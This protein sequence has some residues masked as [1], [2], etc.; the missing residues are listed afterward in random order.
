MTM[1]FFSVLA[2]SCSIPVLADTNKFL[3]TPPHEFVEHVS[4]DN[5]NTSLL[6]EIQSSLPDPLGTGKASDHFTDIEASLGP[7]YAALPKNQYGNLEHVTARYALRRLFVLRHGWAIKGLEPMG[8]TYNSSS[9]AGVLKDQVPAYIEDL[10]EQRLQGRGFQLHELAVLAATIEHL[11]K[12]E[13]MARLGGAFKVLGGKSKINDPRL[14]LSSG[15]A[16]VMLDTYL[17]GFILAEDLPSK[18]PAEVD[19]L[20]K[21]MPDVFAYWPQTQAFARRIQREVTQT[22]DKDAVMEL[23]LKINAEHG[24]NAQ[25]RFNKDVTSAAEHDHEMSFASLAKVMEAVGDQFGKFFDD[26]VCKSMKDT[27]LKME[28]RGTGSIRLADFY[29]PALE[30][31]VW[32]FQESAGYLRELGVLEES[33]PK[34]PRVM[35]ANYLLSPS[36]C[37]AASG[38]YSVCCKNECDGLLGRLE[39]M[40]AGPEA[41]PAAIATMI[42]ALPS[43]TVLAPRILS[44]TSLQRLHDI[45]AT[46]GGTVPLHGRLF[47]QWMHHAYPRECPFPHVS[48]TTDPKLPDEWEQASG[49]EPIATAHEM[50]QYMQWSTNSTRHIPAEDLLPWSQ[51]EELLIVR[52]SG[53]IPEWSQDASI[54]TQ[55]TKRSIVLLSIAGTLSYTL[56]RMFNV[57]SVGA[58]VEPKKFE[59]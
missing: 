16:T 48:G 59:I 10:F 56:I 49:D 54:Q 32:Q 3:V 1:T 38:F 21:D 45:A 53:G 11:I 13:A 47:T 41:T 4:E 35:I 2:L 7:I 37:I 20:V 28:H 8:G 22:S 57:A 19:K 6:H 31:G 23:I 36:N 51:E 25:D 18:A 43:S 42:A 9:P 34:E 52:P 14:V 30:D 40:A 46:H 27:L 58:Y 5:I 33:D 24:G 12:E 50:K 44:D 29:K 26:T 15:D 17:T 39:D 55:G